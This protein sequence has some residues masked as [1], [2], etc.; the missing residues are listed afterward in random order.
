MNTHG[1]ALKDRKPLLKTPSF[2]G[3]TSAAQQSQ[4]L[5]VKRKLR[6]YVDLC[7]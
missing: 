1:Y 6:I 4:R 2:K 3:I 5:C 7:G